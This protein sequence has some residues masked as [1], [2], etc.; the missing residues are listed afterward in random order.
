M[1][2]GDQIAAARRNALDK[3][4][5]ALRQYEDRVWCAI[6]AKKDDLIKYFSSFPLK[7][8]PY[9]LISMSDPDYSLLVRFFGYNE[10]PVY[11]FTREKL[12]IDVRL[13]AYGKVVYDI[14][15][16]DVEDA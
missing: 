11:S 8:D 6:D 3:R 15:L 1:C 13:S 5:R 14:Y 7:D 12:K 9:V 2:L 10:E 4:E 16:A